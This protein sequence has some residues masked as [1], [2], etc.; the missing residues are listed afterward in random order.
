M[1]LKRCEEDKNRVGRARGE[2]LAPSHSHGDC[3]QVLFGRACDV[4]RGRG[5]KGKGSESAESF[6]QRCE[7]VLFGE[8][9]M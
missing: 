3:D 4:G 9:V 2:H 8:R 5:G 6:S 7:Q 1:M